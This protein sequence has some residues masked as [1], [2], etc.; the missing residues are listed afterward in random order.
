MICRKSTREGETDGNN[1]EKGLRI[2][3]PQGVRRLKEGMEK[4]RE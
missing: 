1:R 3:A 4:H 2:R